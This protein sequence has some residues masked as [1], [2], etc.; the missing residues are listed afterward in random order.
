MAVSFIQAVRTRKM[1]LRK[2]LSA[3]RG[4]EA[5]INR[6]QT[7]IRRILG[8]KKALPE[9]QDMVL[10]LTILKEVISLFATASSIASAGFPD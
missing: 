3:V 2:V 8:R 1:Q 7:T 4:V 5:K 10:V 6:I 9:A